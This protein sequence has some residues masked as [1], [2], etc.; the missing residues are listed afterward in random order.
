MRLAFILNDIV[1]ITF[2]AGRSFLAIFQI[3]VNQIN[4]S[5]LSDTSDVDLNDYGCGEITTD[6]EPMVE[7]TWKNC[8]TL[9]EV[10]DRTTVELITNTV[11]LAKEKT[12]CVGLN[13]FLDITPSEDRN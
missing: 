1:E 10:F 8:D 5:D 12:Q 3:H 9:T 11:K 2:V 13:F 6:V 7:N 4:E